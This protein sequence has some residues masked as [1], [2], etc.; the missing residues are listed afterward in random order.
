MVDDDQQRDRSV[1][2]L[3]YDYPLSARLRKPFV[4][5][6]AF[7]ALFVLAWLVGR[8]DVRIGAGAGTGAGGVAGGG[9]AGGMMDEK[10]R[11]RFVE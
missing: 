7:F 9:G 3:T 8:V 4:I 11:K 1:V 5:T 2:W 6:A 10:G